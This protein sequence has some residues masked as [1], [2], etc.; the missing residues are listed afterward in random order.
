MVDFTTQSTLLRLVVRRLDGIRRLMVLMTVMGMLVATMVMQ[1]SMVVN[2][3]NRV[4][5]A[6]LFRRH[7]R[8]RMRHRR[9]RIDDNSHDQEQ[10]NQSIQHGSPR[11]TS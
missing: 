4:V 5:L 8:M 10:R 11:F 7:S 3:W 6:L 1:D 9:Q 2:V